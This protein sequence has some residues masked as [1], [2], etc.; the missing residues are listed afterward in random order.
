MGFL[1]DQHWCVV[2]FLHVAQLNQKLLLILLFF[3]HHGWFLE[4]PTLFRRVNAAHCLLLFRA[5]LSSF[6]FFLQ[7]NYQV[8]KR[9]TWV[10]TKS[11]TRPYRNSTAYKHTER[12]LERMM[13]S[14]SH[15]ISCSTPFHISGCKISIPSCNGGRGG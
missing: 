6:P 13:L 7:R 14:S 4:N 3:F 1:H 9:R 2:E 5:L 11:W 12:K 15:S 10:C 8:P